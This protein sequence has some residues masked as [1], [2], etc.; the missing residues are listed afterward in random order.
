[1]VDRNVEE[2]IINS[3]R[4]LGCDAANILPVH[5]LQGDLGVD[6]TEMIELASLV[7]GEFGL[8]T[9]RIDLDG[10]RTV[11]DLAGRVEVL[12]AQLSDEVQQRQ[13]MV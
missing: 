12:L 13:V 11:A 3:L 8:V 9:Q 1:M 5:D 2:S 10:I 6:S 4:K 7:R